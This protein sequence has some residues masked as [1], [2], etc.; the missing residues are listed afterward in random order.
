M[1]FPPSAID[2]PG[3]P[4]SAVGQ[5]GMQMAGIGVTLAISIVSG[6]ITGNYR[7][8]HNDSNLIIGISANDLLL[9]CIGILQYLSR[10]CMAF[11]L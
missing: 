1:P 8:I 5:S 4:L 2:M 9:T 7:S 11:L 3:E 6:L 10:C